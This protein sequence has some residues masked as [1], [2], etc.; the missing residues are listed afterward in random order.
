[1]F[2]QHRKR[3]LRADIKDALPVAF[4]PD[5]VLQVLPTAEFRNVIAIKWDITTDLL[6]VLTTSMARAR[7][8]DKLLDR[9]LEI[10]SS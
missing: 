5:R 3:A 7:E 6:D 2:D 8:I 10:S 1:M 9:E 4:E